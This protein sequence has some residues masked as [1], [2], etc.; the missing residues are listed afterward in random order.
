MLQWFSHASASWHWGDFSVF[1]M[2]DHIMFLISFNRDNQGQT[3]WMR[4]EKLECRPWALVTQH[5]LVMQVNIQ[6][7]TRHNWIKSFARDICLT[8]SLTSVVIVIL[9]VYRKA[10]GEADTWNYTGSC[11]DWHHCGSALPFLWLVAST[12]LANLTS[13]WGLGAAR[14]LS[15]QWAVA[16][17]LLCMAASS[18]PTPQ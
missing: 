7:L 9:F 17:I 11:G 3:L 2:Q 15:Q 16:L 14:S 12:A 8:P 1:L 13:V 4:N 18:L 5:S 6:A 10:Q